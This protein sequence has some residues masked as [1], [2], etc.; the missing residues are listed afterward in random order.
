MPSNEQMIAAVHAYVDG[1]AREDA[2]AVVA[3]FAEDAVV[4]DP[5]GGPVRRGRAEFADFFA[6]TVGTGAKLSLDGPIRLGPDYAA[7]PFHVDIAWEGQAMRIDVIDVFRFAPSG[8]I[9]HMQ[10]F[11]GDSNFLPASKEA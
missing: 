6:G 8:K 7:F 2:A 5:V 4:E 10:A 3:L 11:F 9:S 1:F